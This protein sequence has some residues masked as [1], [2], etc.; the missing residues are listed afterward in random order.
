MATLGGVGV[1][2]VRWSA[3]PQGY[4]LLVHEENVGLI[5]AREIVLIG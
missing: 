2:P 3:A 5:P 4:L 1:R